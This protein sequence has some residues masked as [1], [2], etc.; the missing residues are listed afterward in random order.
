MRAGSDYSISMIGRRVTGMCPYCAAPGREGYRSLGLLR[1]SGCGLL[2]RF[3]QPKE[4][5]L[6]EFYKTEWQNPE[7]S[8]VTGAT[9]ESVARY[10]ALNL[11]RTVGRKDLAGL[12]VLELGAGRGNFA[13]A[14]MSLGADVIASDPY[15][16]K[17]LESMGVKSVPSLD[18][19]PRRLSFD[20]AVSNSVIEH[21]AAPWRVLRDLRGRLVERGWLYVS[22]P[23]A[24][25]LAACIENAEWSQA[26]NPGHLFLFTS[27]C[28]RRVLIDSGYYSV[29]RHRWLVRHSSGLSRRA[30]H[31]ALQLTH[32]G[33]EIH[34]TARRAD[35]E[36]DYDG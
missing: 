17:Q 7:A 3:P 9:D 6:A 20:I 36:A 26:K 22:T 18:D 19:L 27:Q 8:A 12:H 16:Y 34:Y 35:R 25:G 11:A 31:T 32:L 23:N 28:L 10:Y 30:L 14:L 21:L 2:F 5:D 33:G 1:C 13:R 29:I 4:E 15:S 24:S